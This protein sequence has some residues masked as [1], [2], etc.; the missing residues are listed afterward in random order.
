MID[1]NSYR[2]FIDDC[3]EADKSNREWHVELKVATGVSWEFV[4][5]EGSGPEN[6]THYRVVYDSPPKPR[7]W[8]MNI[9]GTGSV[10]L[11]DSKESAEKCRESFRFVETIHVREVTDT[12]SEAEEP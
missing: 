11:H 4:N 6:G 10:A 8:W 5:L 7:E 2:K 1:W 12:V 3:E 9:Y